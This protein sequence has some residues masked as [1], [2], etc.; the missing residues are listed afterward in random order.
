MWAQTLDMM[1]ACINFRYGRQNDVM[2]GPYHPSIP[3]LCHFLIPEIDKTPGRFDNIDFVKRY[4]ARVF[5]DESGLAPTGQ[6]H[7]FCL[8][9][10]SDFIYEVSLHQIPVWT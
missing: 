10:G 1:S 7:F 6:P 3:L 2:Y 8:R 9:V 4:S 5:F